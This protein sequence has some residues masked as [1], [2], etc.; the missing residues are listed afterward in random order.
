MPRKRKAEQDSFPPGGEEH[1][2][3][4]D[5]KIQDVKVNG[6][7]KP[8]VTELG[9]DGTVEREATQLQ[10]LPKVPSEAATHADPGRQWPLRISIDA[11]ALI[12]NHPNRAHASRRSLGTSMAF[13]LC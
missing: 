13:E 4:E 9:S 12:L 11:L 6:K 2:C 5:I 7:E 3:G 8:E 1:E 10:P